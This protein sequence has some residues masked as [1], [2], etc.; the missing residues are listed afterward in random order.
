MAQGTV[1]VLLIANITV[2]ISHRTPLHSIIVTD[3]NIQHLLLSSVTVQVWKY[4]YL[5][6]RLQ[7]Q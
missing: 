5:L 7:K 4:S 2:I 1:I 6:A 3:A